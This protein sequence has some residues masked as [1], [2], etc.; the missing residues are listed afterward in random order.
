MCDKILALSDKNNVLWYGHKIF[1]GH[2]EFKDT[3]NNNKI[4]ILEKSGFSKNP[5]FPDPSRI[6]G[7]PSMGLKSGPQ[8]LPVAKISDL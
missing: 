1:W 8:G 7:S 5:D 3:K 2:K 6:S 4:R